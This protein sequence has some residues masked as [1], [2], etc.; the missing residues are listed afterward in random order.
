MSGEL[1]ALIPDCPLW[2]ENWKR[3]VEETKR[4]EAQAPERPRGL[5]E[6]GQAR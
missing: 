1:Y 3:S 5:W 4:Q 6:R 2:W